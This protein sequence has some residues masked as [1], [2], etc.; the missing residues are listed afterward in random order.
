MM[1]RRAFLRGAAGAG[2]ALSL[3]IAIRRDFLVLMKDRTGKIL[4]RLKMIGDNHFKGEA[5]RTGRISRYNVWEGS[6]L[7]SI[8][9]VI[10]YGEYRDGNVFF[11]TSKDVWAGDLITMCNVKWEEA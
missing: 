5:K 7:V 6:R 11:I 2:I 3:P 1:N 9:K 4:C 8:G 10:R